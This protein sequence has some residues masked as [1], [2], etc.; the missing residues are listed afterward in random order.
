[1]DETTL[2]LLSRAFAATRSVERTL[3]GVGFGPTS[4][5]VTKQFR[6]LLRR[7]KETTTITYWDEDG[8][9]HRKT[10]TL[11]HLGLAGHLHIETLARVRT[12]EAREARV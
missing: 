7:A 4:A 12:V 2:N 6:H 11:S 5:K 8:Q 10:L 9:P 3:R 1:M